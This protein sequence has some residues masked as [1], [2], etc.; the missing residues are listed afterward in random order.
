LVLYSFKQK[1]SKNIAVLYAVVFLLTMSVLRYGIGVD[2]F[3][4]QEYYIEISNIGH[5]DYAEYGFILLSQLSVY[6][7]IGFQGVVAVYAI[8]T[9][10]LFAVF[11][12]KYSNN[13]L[14][15]IYIFTMLPLL[16]LASF[17]VIRQFLAVALFSFSIR[18][19][20]EKKLILYIACLLFTA[21]FVHKSVIIMLPMYFILTRNLNI[22][23]YIFITLLYIVLL[24]FVELI[25]TTL[26][27][28]QIY[29]N[30]SI[31]NTGVNYLVLI[32]FILFAYIYYWKKKLV[33]HKPENIIFINL[34]FICTLVSFS[35]M[36]TDLP[37][38][39]FLRLSSFF[40]IAIPIILVN[41][42]PVIKSYKFRLV[43][44]FGLI[45]ASTLYFYAVLIFKGGLYKLTPYTTIIFN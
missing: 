25:I 31:K 8:L 40:T 3:T 26:G 14:L 39:P 28:S 6:L 45:F 10:I 17:N 12:S 20:F 24:Q 27:F 4:Y 1:V 18:Y 34:T 33:S 23:N 19:I 42:L 36:F 15:S 29:L 37:S 2:F 9:V 7:G 32:F 35:S 21:F 41:I 38:G 43:Y 22:F 44:F 11:Y 5:T 13:V 30:G 16:Y